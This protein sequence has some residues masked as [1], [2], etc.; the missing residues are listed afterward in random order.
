MRTCLIFYPCPI[1]LV[2][3][4]SAMLILSTQASQA[5]SI[6][7]LVAIPTSNAI[8]TLRLD[9]HSSYGDTDD[10]DEKTISVS[11]TTDFLFTPSL[12]QL[13]LINISA[14]NISLGNALYG[15]DFFC[16]P[17]FGC[18]HLNVS[19][20]NVKITLLNPVISAVAP[21]GS[22]TF[23]DGS[24]DVHADY[25]LSGFTVGNG[26]SDTMSTSQFAGVVTFSGS[27]VYLNQCRLSPLIIDFSKESLPSNVSSVRMTITSNLSNMHFQGSWIVKATGP[28][29]N[30][31]GVVNGL[32]LSFV[33]SGWGTPSGDVNGDQCTD[34][35]D[36][37]EVLSAWTD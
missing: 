25:T 26:S 21:D 18:Q 9:I 34:G 7:K 35:A 22:V 24:F 6:A 36:L 1:E 10:T 5:D 33:L 8:L 2:Y 16:F 37:A 31:D 13:S 17:F 12:P 4:G 27:N 3:F 32:D 23:Q 19:L 15:F 14:L 28:D 29:L 11:G 30:V 20:E